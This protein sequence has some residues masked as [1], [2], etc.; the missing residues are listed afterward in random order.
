MSNFQRIVRYEP[1]ENCPHPVAAG[2]GVQFAM[3][4]VTST[5]IVWAAVIHAGGGSE[6]YLTWA[7]FAT[8]LV[9]GITTLVQTYRVGILGCGYVLVTG[10]FEA[11]IAVAATAIERGGPALLAALVLS[12]GLVQLVL[13]HRM[14]LLRRILT[15][16]VTGTMI[17]LIAAIVMPAAF[18]MLKTPAG[19][20]AGAVPASACATLA[21]FVFIALFSSGAWRLW[22]PFAAIAAGCLTAAAYGHYDLARVFEA[23]WFGL[24]SLSG[25]PGI[26]LEFGTDFWQL[27]P[28]FIF[29]NVVAA[30]ETIVSG[31]SIQRVSWR[32]E[33]AV[34]YRAV[35]G[36][37][38]A[39]GAGDL[40]AGLLGSVPM[41][42][43]SSSV[44]LAELTGVASRRVGLYTG[45]L[46]AALAVCPKA[47]ALFVAI[48]A[49]VGGAYLMVLL[50]MLFVFGA[51]ILVR[52]GIDYRKSLI[53]G[54]SFWI[55]LGFEHGLLFPQYL[56]AGWSGMLGNGVLT[57]GVT[58]IGLTLFL[59]SANSRQRRI[60]TKLDI[61]ALPG[62]LDFLGDF[63]M[64]QRLNEEM[65][66]RLE[67]VAEEA[68]SALIEH[69][70]PEA[71]TR[72]LRMI[73]RVDSAAAE[74]EFLA[75][76]AE[77]NLEDRIADLSGDVEPS[78]QGLALRMLRHRA[79]SVRYAQYNDMDVLTLRLERER[80]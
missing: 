36:A 66:Q 68:L 78:E 25:H 2:L 41:T 32:K 80:S 18:D 48:P 75:G 42:T 69:L 77:G 60:E 62:I 1:S 22:A 49:S 63:S 28:A 64:R 74:L 9:S 72:R 17:M 6:D 53:A 12:A 73:A 67:A 59:E 3:L 51:K 34:D 11:F 14:A 65:K 40:L 30:T 55:G 7:V 23:P 37:L 52:D 56:S 76:S 5:V 46:F 58:V 38:A 70:G 16:T 61:E 39:D 35:Q 10:S 20:P 4:V 45:V 24:P 79:S 57:G 29:V 19:A 13:A 47:T 26:D 21:V 27:L 50:S 54:V 44:S 31:I 15:H 43:Y 33:R 71:E 8:L